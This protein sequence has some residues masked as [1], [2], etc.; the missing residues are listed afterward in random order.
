MNINEDVKDHVKASKGNLHADLDGSGQKD[1]NIRR[2]ISNGAVK[3]NH[4]MNG[5]MNT[6][7]SG[8]MGDNG[9]IN[10]GKDLKGY[11]FFNS[12]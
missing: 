9:T 6:S 2:A 3:G 10:A 12:S 7:S 11:I 5:F 4:Q 1:G 8:L